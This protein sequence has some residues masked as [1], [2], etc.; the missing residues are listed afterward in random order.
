MLII[1]ID[2]FVGDAL[3]ETKNKWHGFVS[4]IFDPLNRSIDNSY[5]TLEEEPDN[6]YDPNAVMVVCRGKFFGTMGYVG[7][8]YTAKIKQFFNEC[9]LYRVDMEDK[10][11]VGGKR[12]SIDYKMGR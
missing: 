11:E 6:E 5:L 9:E 8:E 10:E 12:N 4:S 1:N 2:L 7:R 3:C